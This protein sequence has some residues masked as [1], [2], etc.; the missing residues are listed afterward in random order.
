MG[1]HAGHSE[2]VTSAA[3]EK[4]PAC[5]PSIRSRRRN[6]PLAAWRQARAVELATQGL[7][8]DLIARHVGYANRG[9]A[10]RVVR[11][12]LRKQTTEAA[13]VL[14]QKELDRLDA[15]QAAVWP[16]AMAGEV[17]AVTAAHKIILAR[18]RLLGL[19]AEDDQ[20]TQTFSGPVVMT[21][22]EVVA[23]AAPPAEAD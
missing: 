4:L 11:E 7:S 20:P 23:H 18:C 22:D 17:S 9:T 1:R 14:L 16:R 13:A 2:F 8:Y 6:R 5:T 3:A 19:G 10:Y 21:V 12:A 15:L